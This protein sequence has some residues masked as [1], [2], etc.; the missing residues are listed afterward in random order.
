MR[1]KIHLFVFILAFLKADVIISAHDLPSK[2]REFLQSH[3][4]AKIGLVQRDEKSY[5]VYLSDGTELEFDSAGAWRQ[6]EA[7]R[8]PLSYD[9]LSPQIAA[10]LRS[11]FKNMTMRELERKINH[12]KIKFHNGSEI[13]IDFNGTILH[14]EFED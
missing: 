8:K 9:I 10:V 12:Y 13:I 3:F 5:E 14:K 11:E 7:K 4:D 2:S 6:I 1:A